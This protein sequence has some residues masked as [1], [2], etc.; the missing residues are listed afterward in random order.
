MAG[1]LIMFLFSTDAKMAA[2]IMPLFVIMCEF[3]NGVLQPRELMPAVWRYTIYYIGPFTYWISGIVTMVLTGVSVTCTDAE[4]M[5]FDV[6]SNTTCSEYASDWLS[7]SKGYLANPDASGDC[8]YCQ[9]ANGEDVSVPDSLL[10]RMAISLTG[11]SVSVYD[12]SHQRHCMA[13]SGHLSAFHSHQLRLGFRVC[14]CQV[15]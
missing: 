2:N 13:I 15:D 8:G 1:L 3:F 14:V 9:Y 12:Q 10:F 7:G 6:P 4:L 5:R 11:I